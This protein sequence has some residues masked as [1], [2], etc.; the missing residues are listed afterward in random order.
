MKRILLAGLCLCC[1]VPAFAN[2][3][4]PEGAIQEGTL[5]NQQLIHDAMLGVAADVAT[6][7]CDSP[8]N[9]M[10]YVMAM[11]E[12]QVGSRYWRELWVVQGCGKTFPVKIRFSEKGVG[13]AN[14]VI[15]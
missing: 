8:E 11:P 6:Q 2:S 15:E 3:G 9:F 10:P 12:G 1:A 14:W 4:L 13:A 5:S 7:G